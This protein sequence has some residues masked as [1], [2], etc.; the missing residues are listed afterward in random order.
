MKDT[1]MTLR[2]LFMNKMDI[3]LNVFGTLVMHRVADI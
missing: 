1:H 2:N 3:H